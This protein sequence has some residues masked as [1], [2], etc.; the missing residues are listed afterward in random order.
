DS[1]LFA[2]ACVILISLMMERVKGSV[3]LGLIILPILAM[4][5]LANNRRMVWVQVLMVFVTLYFA[6]P[7]NPAKKKIKYTA[8]ALSP[9][10]L[11]YLAIGWDA[12]GGFFKP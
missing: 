10:I 2:A 1:I 4:G 7:T 9:L 6:T 11:A 3:R 12:K 8:F 5:M